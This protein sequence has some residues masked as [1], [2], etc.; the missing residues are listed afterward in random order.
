MKKLERKDLIKVKGGDAWNAINNPER[1][2][3]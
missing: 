1:F 3:P 2:N